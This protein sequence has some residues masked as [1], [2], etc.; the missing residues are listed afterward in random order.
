MKI[1][2][3]V[4]RVLFILLLLTPI[5]GASGVFPAPT[6][7]L[8]TPNG[9]AFMSALI[10]TGYMLPLLAVLCAVCVVLLIMNRTALTAALIAPMTV[11]VIMFHAFVDTGLIN[12]A[13]SLGGQIIIRDAVSQNTADT[14]ACENSPTAPK[15]PGLFSRHSDD[16]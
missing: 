2:T 10:A 12:P 14:P 1:L 8:Y 7:D 6:A 5:L 15:R 13:A 4:L 11:N 3:I 16:S 9:W